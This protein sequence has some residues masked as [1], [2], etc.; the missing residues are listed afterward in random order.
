M[1]RNSHPRLD[2]CLLYFTALWVCTE[3]RATAQDESQAVCCAVMPLGMDPKLCDKCSVGKCCAD[4][5]C[6]ECRP[7][8]KCQE[9]EELYCSGTIDF[10]YSCRKCPNGTFSDTKSGFCVPW[11]D[12]KKQDSKF[13]K[14]SHPRD[15]MSTLIIERNLE[16]FS[17]QIAAIIP[18]TGFMSSL[19]I[20]SL[21]STVT[22]IF[23]VLAAAGVLILLLMTILLIV[24][25]CAQ[26][27]AT[28]LWWKNLN[29]LSCKSL[30]SHLLRKILPLQFPEEENGGKNG[31]P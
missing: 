7:L 9:G 11:E 24:C 8:P 17:S 10:R 14:Q 22:S 4:S 5:R 13:F 6:R 27:K 30:G 18:T 3:L 15:Y 12:C 28:F 25:A 23:T 20:V 26:K 21:D 31:E 19:Y 1:E 29:L 16:F 2:A